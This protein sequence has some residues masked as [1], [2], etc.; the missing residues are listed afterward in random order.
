MKISD[1]LR[2]LADQMDSIQND[3]VIAKAANN[4]DQNE[5]DP[6]DTDDTLM[7][8]PLQAKLE[9]LRKSEG[10]PNAYDDDDDQEL[11]YIRKNA[12]MNARAKHELADDD[13][14]FEG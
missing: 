1:L 10:M 2:G 11:N 12:G 7:V 9:L 8:P 13:G 14:P 3:P 4:I 5:Q 6:E